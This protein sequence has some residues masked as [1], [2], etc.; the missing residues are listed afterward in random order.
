MLLP[1]ILFGLAPAT[2]EPASGPSAS[3]ESKAQDSDNGELHRS[4]RRPKLRFRQ[5]LGAQG[6]G[7]GDDLGSFQGHRFVGVGGRAHAFDPGQVEPAPPSLPDLIAS[8]LSASAPKHQTCFL[9]SA[10]RTWKLRK[11]LAK[12]LQDPRHPLH[13]PAKAQGPANQAREELYLRLESFAR[14]L[15][16]FAKAKRAPSEQRKAQLVDELR[17]LLAGIIAFSSLQRG[18]FGLA[19]RGGTSMGTYQAGFLYYFSEFLKAH[20]KRWGS[21]VELKL[22]ESQR[23]LLSHFELATG[24]SAGALNTL[25]L[26]SEGCRK[27]RRKP[28]NSAF[29]K[30]WV[31]TGMVGRHGYPGLSSSRKRPLYQRGFLNKDPIE[32][33]AAI[34]QSDLESGEGYESQCGI[35]IGL[36]VTRAKHDRVPL[37]SGHGPDPNIQVHRT[38]ER[39]AFS[40]LFHPDP[41]DP[42]KQSLE[43]R[44]RRP[45]PAPHRF[46]LGGVKDKDKL[47]A[48]YLA[49]GTP[50]SYQSPL[51]PKNVI[52]TALASGAMPFAFAP[53]SLSYTSFGADGQVDEAHSGRADF[54]DGGILDGRPLSFAVDLEEWKRADE[55]AQR[56]QRVQQAS[57]SPDPSPKYQAWLDELHLGFTNAKSL[58]DWQLWQARSDLYQQ[59]AENKIRPARELD[60]TPQ[61]WHELLDVLPAIPRTLVFVEPTLSTWSPKQSR[62]ADETQFTA[63][64]RLLPAIGKHFGNFV[65]TA[66]DANLVHSVKQ[67]PWIRG[68]NPGDLRPRVVIPRRS[69]AIAGERLYRFMAFF[70]R[71]FREFDFFAGMADAQRFTQEQD[72]TLRLS[73]A[74]PK[75]KDPRLSCINAYFRAGLDEAKTRLNKHKF[76]KAL[77]A[78][79]VRALLGESSFTKLNHIEKLSKVK[80]RAIAK[81]DQDWNSS[82]YTKKE[83]E[84]LKLASAAISAHNFGAMLLAMHNFKHWQRQHKKAPSQNE[85]FDYFF[86]ALAHAEFEYVDLVRLGKILGLARVQVAS[87]RRGLR[88]RIART[89]CRHL[90]QDAINFFAKPQTKKLHR[91]GI[92]VLGKGAADLFHTYD[93]RWAFDLGLTFDGLETKLLGHPFHNRFRME[94][95]LFRAH[96][97]G[98]YPLS[99]RSLASPM[100]TVLSL[101]DLDLATR[102]GLRAFRLSK[103]LQMSVVTGPA[104][105]WTFNLS[106]L[107]P[108]KGPPFG[109]MMMRLG[110]QFGVEVSI[111][112]RIYVELTGTQ[113]LYERGA[114]NWKS[115]SPNGFDFFTERHSS[116]RGPCRIKN[117]RG[118]NAD[119][120]GVSMSVGWRWSQ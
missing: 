115:F 98:D 35:D 56:V 24:S 107:E 92:S 87:K 38:L 16:T 36:T 109:L 114:D 104:L 97:V 10:K 67:H 74:I 64:K 75:I 117:G 45:S 111:L 89:I 103:L 100:N 29:Y 48:F 26:A 71:D 20:A 40:L 73:G 66:R 25:I 54:V 4:F 17:E 69:L 53:R 12:N 34:V 51:K 42:N 14:S 113:W 101:I 1:A 102:A 70:E 15:E 82:N 46:G 90:M 106:S 30:A 2:Q 5:G 112:Q 99:R 44:N 79:S 95:A 86:K 118:L 13:I 41:K 19:V 61:S 119:C 59:L 63:R 55:V 72:P 60:P 8:C 27:P 57:L 21:P 91:L 22:P 80:R 6:V 58:R 76:A 105:S 84:E 47:D 28:E 116:F 77:P 31:N 120:F 85:N 94:W 18:R 108:Q 88:P 96:G 110:A 7:Q 81:M 62:H 32:A 93:P 3:L 65:G 43:L 37:F 11:Q 9:D 33:G 68:R 83:R 52:D 49:Y 50:E 78:C 39:F 23:R